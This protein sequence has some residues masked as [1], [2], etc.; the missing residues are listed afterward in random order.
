[1]LRNVGTFV[2]DYTD[3]HE[4]TQRPS[5]CIEVDAVLIYISQILRFLALLLIVPEEPQD[6]GDNL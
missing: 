1:M 6:G 5:R 4:G 2:T 3:S